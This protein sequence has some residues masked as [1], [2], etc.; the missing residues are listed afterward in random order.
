MADKLRHFF[1]K[2]HFSQ[3]KTAIVLYDGNCNLCKGTVAFISKRNKNNNISLLP[4]QSES[5]KE[6]MA[7]RNIDANADSVIF[8]DE[9]AVYYQSKAILF[10]LK[11]LNKPYKLLAQIA[12]VFPESFLNLLYRIIAKNR[13]RWFGKAKMDACERTSS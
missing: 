2:K 8:I 6:L 1:M 5:A 4:L 7:E 3:N 11:N 13:Y 10:I 9:N 12:S